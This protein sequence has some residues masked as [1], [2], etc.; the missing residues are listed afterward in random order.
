MSINY[1]LRDTS[2]LQW[3]EGRVQKWFPWLHSQQCLCSLHISDKTEVCPS[4]YSY[5]ASKW[6]LLIDRLGVCFS[7]QSVKCPR[8]SGL[9]PNTFL[10][11][12][13]LWCPGTQAFL[14]TR[15]SPSGPQSQLIQR[16]PV[17]G[18][19]LPAGFS[20]AWDKYWGQGIPVALVNGDS[21]ISSWC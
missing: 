9:P 21:F 2:K 18:G 10:V 17:C 11:V 15:G 13:V 16:H 5:R 1:F 3:S 4:G 6:A 7:W 12:T 20:K 8:Y 19:C 14:S